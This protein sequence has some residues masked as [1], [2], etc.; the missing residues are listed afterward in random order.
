M[1]GPPSRRRL[2]EMA[3]L[4]VLLVLAAI[5]ERWQGPKQ[6]QKTAEMPVNGQ[7]MGH[8][9]LVDGDSFFLDGDEVRMVGIDAPEGRQNCTREGKA[10]ACGEA[11]KRE[12]ARL[13]G[14][15]PVSCDATERDQHQRLLSRCKAGGIELNRQMVANGFAVSFGRFYQREEQDA[16]QQRRGIWSSE[17]DRPQDWRHANGI[18]G[19]H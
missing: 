2:V 4:A 19:S 16:R 3:G 1:N 15:R 12:L 10:W 11:A 9:K 5:A 13:I 14:G 6:G 18:G 7:V 17:F 8:P